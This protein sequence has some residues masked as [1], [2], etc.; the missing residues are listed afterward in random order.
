V[1]KTAMSIAVTRIPTVASVD[2]R[3][4]LGNPESVVR[5]TSLVFGTRDFKGKNGVPSHRV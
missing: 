5:R 2:V 1:I 3:L 4:G